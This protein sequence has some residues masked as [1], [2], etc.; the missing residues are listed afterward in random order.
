MKDINYPY[1]CVVI[2][3]EPL[4]LPN[5][6]L[7]EWS[8]VYGI[9]FNREDVNMLASK[10]NYKSYTGPDIIDIYIGYL[11]GCHNF[12]KNGHQLE[13]GV[14][15]LKWGTEFT[16][17]IPLHKLVSCVQNLKYKVIISDDP[18]EIKDGETDH[19]WVINKDLIEREL[20]HLP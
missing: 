5:D 16:D 19:D 2:F 7:T 6:R 15:K 1:D 4:Y 14:W 17:N 3:D 8:N 13:K 12:L 18:I 10:P 20:N 11:Q 9:L